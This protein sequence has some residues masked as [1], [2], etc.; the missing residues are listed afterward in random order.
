MRNPCWTCVTSAFDISLP[1]L[2]TTPYCSN[3]MVSEFS[4]CPVSRLGF[5]GSTPLHHAAARRSNIWDGPILFLINC[6]LIL[7]RSD[8]IRSYGLLPCFFSQL[9]LGRCREYFLRCFDQFYQWK[10][11]T[12]FSPKLWLHFTQT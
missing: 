11:H 3:A 9:L 8:T 5:S 1:S 6:S 2:S 10:Y 4:R 7:G 12:V